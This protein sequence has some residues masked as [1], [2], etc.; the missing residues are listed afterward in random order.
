MVSVTLVVLRNLK[1]SK[2]QAEECACVI[3]ELF[4]F[5][6]SEGIE[7]SPEKLLRLKSS[8]ER[9]LRIATKFSKLIVE[10]F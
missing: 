8:L 2:C 10:S 9:V 5:S 7:K 4:Q 6:G 3:N 1:L